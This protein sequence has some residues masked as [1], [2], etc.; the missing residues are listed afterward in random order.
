MGYNTSRNLTFHLKGDIV[1]QGALRQL[2]RENLLNF[3]P[4]S[5]TAGPAI[6]SLRA[7]QYSLTAGPAILLSTAQLA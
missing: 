6:L 1:L 5:L 2:Q 4:N 7:P 3:F